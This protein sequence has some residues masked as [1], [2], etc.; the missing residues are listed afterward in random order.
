[1][2]HTKHKW[3]LHTLSL[4]FSKNVVSAVFQL[5]PSHTYRKKNIYLIS[6]LFSRGLK[7]ATAPS[8]RV[9]H[10][11]PGF[12]SAWSRHGRKGMTYFNRLVHRRHRERVEEI[13][14]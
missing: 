1:M 7:K 8:L 3:R 12:Q 13:R 5:D 10:M 6:R 14:R 9:L 11:I 4:L 2:I